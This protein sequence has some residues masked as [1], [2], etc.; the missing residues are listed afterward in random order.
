[1]RG[2]MFVCICNAISDK[3]IKT[4]LKHGAD[5]PKQIYKFCNSSIQCGKCVET[6]Y[7][8]I[9]SRKKSKSRSQ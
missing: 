9:N 6:V 7:E 2:N 1:M 3:D 8:M 4:A 5:S